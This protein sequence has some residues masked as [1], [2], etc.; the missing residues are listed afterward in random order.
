MSERSLYHVKVHPKSLI[1]NFQS[2]FNS[3]A[4]KC[5][6]IYIMALS[7]LTSLAFFMHIPIILVKDIIFVTMKSLLDII[8]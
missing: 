8:K 7:D 4:Q 6:S 1:Q 3:G 5:K 2:E